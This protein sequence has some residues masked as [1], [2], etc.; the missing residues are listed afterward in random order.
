MKGIRTKFEKIGK[1][2]KS[3]DTRDDHD[4]NQEDHNHY[5]IIDHEFKV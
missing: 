3:L 5:V 4:C 1:W 2:W